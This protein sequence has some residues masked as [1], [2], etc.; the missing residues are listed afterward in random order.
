[1]CV[2]PNPGALPAS[3]PRG[4]F[5]RGRAPLLHGVSTGIRGRY[6]SWSR[7]RVRLA[8]SAVLPAS[9]MAFW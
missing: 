9:S 4:V 7:R 1:V 2:A 8:V 3:G 6:P 5:H